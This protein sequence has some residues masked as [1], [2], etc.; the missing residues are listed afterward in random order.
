MVPT[1]AT[2][3]REGDVIIIT[4]SEQMDTASVE[5]AFKATSTGAAK[6]TFKWTPDKTVVTVDPKFTYPKA[7]TAA[8]AKGTYAF[9]LGNA[10]KDANGEALQAPMS[11][12]YALLYRR[13]TPPRIAFAQRTP[14]T[15]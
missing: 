13:I 15:S 8:V 2:K 11:A 5:A 14:R 1:T 12:S 6:P 3:V 4:F 7:S 9:T 10:A